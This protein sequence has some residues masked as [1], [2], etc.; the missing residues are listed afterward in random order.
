MNRTK[1]D[2][3]LEMT[4]AGV[5]Y[6][7][8]T[9]V[10]YYARFDRKG[11][12]V[13][14]TRVTFRAGELVDTKPKQG[15]YKKIDGVYKWEHG[16]DIPPALYIARAVFYSDTIPA[17]NDAGLQLWNKLA[18]ADY[19]G[20]I[21]AEEEERANN[22]QK[23]VDAEGVTVVLLTPGALEPSADAERAQELAHYWQKAAKDIERARNDAERAGLPPF[24]ILSEGNERGRQFIQE[25][26]AA[27]HNAGAPKIIGAPFPPDVD[28]RPP[29]LE[30]I[31]PARQYG[32]R[33]YDDRGVV[34]TDDERLRAAEI[35]LGE[36][37]AEEERARN[38]RA[39]KLADNWD[40][41]AGDIPRPFKDAAV[42]TARNFKIPERTSAG[43]LVAAYGSF[44]GEKVRISAP[45]GGGEYAP[46]LGVVIVG[47]S[48]SK[49]SPLIEKIAERA[50]EY[51]TIEKGKAD[52]RNKK[53]RALKKAYERA[54][55]ELA[56]KEY[57]LAQDENDFQAREEVARAQRIRDSLKDKYDKAEAPPRLFVIVYRSGEGL[58]K[59]LS[60]LQ[61]VGAAFKE[62]N[63][64]AFI[65]LDEGHRIF[66]GTQGT[67]YTIDVFGVLSKLLDGKG[68]NKGIVLGTENAYSRDGAQ[69]LAVG[70]I[71][72]TQTENCSC[73]FNRRLKTQGFLNR[74]IW[75]FSP[76][77]HEQTERN[78][79][80]A[81]RL[82]NAL[83]PYYA[84]YDAAY[85][86]RDFK[87]ISLSPG[88]ANIWEK[89]RGE[90]NEKRQE[91]AETLKDKQNKAYDAEQ[92]ATAAFLGKLE[93]QAL[94]I[95]LI[96]H[97]ANEHSAG[98]VENV[99]Q[100]VPPETMQQA[101]D[102]CGVIAE[103]RGKTLRQIAL[104]R[105]ESIEAE[106]LAQEGGGLSP[107]AQAV[108]TFLLSSDKWE[109]V[110]AINAKVKAYQ[111]KGQRTA[112]DQELL[113]SGLLVIGE[114]EH[115]S[116]RGLG[117]RH[118]VKARAASTVEEVGES[119]ELAAGDADSA[120][121]ADNPN[122]GANVGAVNNNEVPF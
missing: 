66:E 78:A 19:V 104:A 69:K 77:S 76:Y 95:V 115:I 106:E 2:A 60:Q 21:P 62:K 68:N 34:H 75:L 17:D 23:D 10:I 67:S 16:G 37:Q 39:I 63:N 90:P 92:Y 99:E 44:L 108:Y 12:P 94:R 100:E 7:E 116:T 15:A 5:N 25:T 54:E 50:G 24:V 61:K 85:N 8:Q 57:K 98:R 47:R 35:K 55:N 58:K 18:R 30:W 31:D 22:L 74:L 45:G 82:S 29:F 113:E 20:I 13:A 89:W 81:Q 102:F 43:A 117:E 107:A 119:N 118:A 26:A 36:R 70:V 97:L 41:S 103:E 84:L 112:I 56:E 65:D 40:A 109:S 52:E 86:M 48:N 120:D 87:M 3:V 38:Q 42:A 111:D 27:L 71:A 101:I 4:S 80:A 114:H 105:G 88:A 64:G 121:I 110:T 1:E 46:Y 33:L 6:Q 32:A 79:E 91:G 53:S 51:E 93:E 49:K 122:E 11:T 83:A 9:R 14:A 59:E 72:G 28:S 73:V 96:F